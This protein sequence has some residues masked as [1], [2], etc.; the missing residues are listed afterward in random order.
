MTKSIIKTNDKILIEVNKRGINAILVN[1]EI[2]IGEYDGVDFKEK[3]MK[4]EEFVK[5]I[6]MKV[7][8]LMQSC[9]FV[10]SIVMSDMFYVKFLYD[11]KEII[12]FI[13]EDGEVTYNTEI[14]IPDEIKVK[15]YDCV[16]G[17]KDIF[18]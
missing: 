3:E 5:E 10:L 12:A 9:N 17:F 15:L 14:N 1:G 8:D 11:N 4:H 13:S 18:L 7:K 2:K 16:K 6:V